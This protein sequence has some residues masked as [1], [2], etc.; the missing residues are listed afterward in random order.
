MRLCNV[1]LDLSDD[2]IN[3]I[4]RKFIFASKNLQQLNSIF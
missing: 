1:D 4:R 3:T 2:E